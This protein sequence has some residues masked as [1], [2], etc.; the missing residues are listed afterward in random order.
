MNRVIHA[1]VA[2]N[3]G[4]ILQEESV[5]L[6]ERG[7]GDKVSDQDISARDLTLKSAERRHIE[8]VYGKMGKNKSRTARAL[9]I[10]RSTLDRKLTGP[11]RD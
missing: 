10:S 11:T 4:P 2:I 5:L 8:W 6:S 3:Q 9:G 7:D 1:A